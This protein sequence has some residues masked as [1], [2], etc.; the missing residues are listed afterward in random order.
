METSCRPAFAS[1]VSRA[2]ALL[3]AAVFASA[4]GLAG[5][6][7][8]SHSAPH[9]SYE[10]QAGP[11]YWP[12][13]SPE[14]SACGIGKLQSPIDIP[15]GA[16]RDSR[17]DSIEFDYETTPLRVID[18]GHSVQV[19][20]GPGSEMRIGALRY[21]LKQ[22]HF[23]MPSEERIDG[24][25]YPMVVHMVHKN[26]EG[27]IA[28]VAVLLE[29]GRENRFFASVLRFAPLD[30]GVERTVLY[31]PVN[32]LNILP[33]QRSYYAFAGSLTT[34]PCSEGVSWYVLQ[35]PVQ[36][37]RTQLDAFSRLYHDNA[38]PTQPLNGR[39]VRSGG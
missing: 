38:R 24:K 6:E 36:V 32:A 8:R 34:P 20:F 30:K 26:K 14:Y 28:V 15:S 23:H 19:N 18:N 21:D 16:A 10:G 5:A 27:R 4:S 35:H 7:E 37:S 9:W 22:L 17:L 39:L 3:A 12:R 31:R 2:F 29:E 25:R 33:V 11:T 1:F 13:L